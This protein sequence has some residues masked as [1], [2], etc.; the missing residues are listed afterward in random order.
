MQVCVAVG[1]CARGCVALRTWVH[2]CEG[3]KEQGTLTKVVGQYSLE[4]A[5]ESQK[6][7]LRERLTSPETFKREYG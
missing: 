1:A 5:T 2:V 3:E 7:Y 4:R 6:R